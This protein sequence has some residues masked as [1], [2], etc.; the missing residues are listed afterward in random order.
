MVTG[1][2]INYDVRRKRIGC[3]REHAASLMRDAGPDNVA[4]L[5]QLVA[6]L[7]EVETAIV[8]VF[9]KG[10]RQLHRVRASTP[11]AERSRTTLQATLLRRTLP[12]TPVFNRLKPA[13]TSWMS[14][15][16]RVS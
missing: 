10:R 9:R 11:M 4:E 7:G 15:G 13:L 6:M 3:P 2:I 14:A 1:R 5:A 16:R 12:L 8:D